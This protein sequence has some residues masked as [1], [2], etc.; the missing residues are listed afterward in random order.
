L[1]R[2][3]FLST[4][5]ICSLAI[6]SKHCRQG[7]VVDK[8][9][10]ESKKVYVNLLD[11][12]RRLLSHAALGEWDAAYA[13]WSPDPSLL[14]CYG[15]VYHP[16]RTTL[17]PGRY[18]YTNL[19]T[20]QIA[21]VNEEYEIVDEMAQHLDEEEKTKQFDE[22][23]PDGELIKHNWNLK[24]AKRLLA[25]VFAVITQD[26]SINENNMDVMS[27]SIRNTLNALY[28]YVQPTSEHKTGLV[29]DV[30]IYVEA[31]KLYED[32]FNQ[33]KTS[34]QRSFWCVRVEEHLASLFG[35]GYLRSHAQGIG[36]KLTREGC[37]LSDKSSYFPFRRDLK[38][39]PGVHFF[40][41]YCG[42]VDV[43]WLGTPVIRGRA[44]RISELVS[45]KNKRGAE[46]TRQYSPAKTSACLIL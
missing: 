9:D 25:A 40:V 8:D 10:D 2:D 5:S 18:K 38:S 45:S 32:K 4:S 27:E 37:I 1:L 46:L 31:L 44:A 14:T 11:S 13:I 41:G 19:T 20:W 29:F 35:T 43:Q 24:E 26:T 33:F 34:H 36:N 3:R 30:N 39:L 12:L 23:F 15:T 7:F 21:W 6:T 17:H 28:A 22:I 16:S 42:A